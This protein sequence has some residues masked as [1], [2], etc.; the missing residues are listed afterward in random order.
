MKIK[1]RQSEK[2]FLLVT[3]YMLLVLF[4]TLTGALVAHAVAE[5]QATQRSQASMQALYLAE[6]GVDWAIT[7]LRQNSSWSG[8]TGTITL[9][10][11]T[12]T[13][14][15]LGSNRRRITVLGTTNQGIT[16]ARSVESI[17]LVSPNPLFRY[18]MF[19]SNSVTLNG[20]GI[21][22]SYDSSQGP[23]NPA[24]AGS[25]GDVGTNGITAGNVS[26]HGNV[27]ISGNAYSGT[28]SDP[29][30]VITMTDNDV[31]TGSK[32]PLSKPEPMLPVTAPDGNLGNLSVS[33][34]T[35]TTLPGGMY[36]YTNIDVTGNGRLNFTGPTMIYVTGMLNIAGNGIGTATNLPPNL[37]IYVAGSGSVDIGGNGNFY[38]GVY[39]PQSLVSIHGNG[40]FYGSAIGDTVTTT[41]NGNVHYDFALQTNGGLGPAQVTVL[42][43]QDLS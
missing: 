34:N 10:S 32:L 6:S 23:Y 4:F 1:Q 20:Q 39:A 26:L 11:Y 28:G 36:V 29:N 43:W 12:V 33:G 38:G 18:A 17:V 21:T 14:A 27:Q 25:K 19:G 41:G 9:G 7:Q 13:L 15:N 40:A 30:V 3:F 8:G 35:T 37:I 2:G 5:V 24:T 22:D 42:S 31:I 16:V